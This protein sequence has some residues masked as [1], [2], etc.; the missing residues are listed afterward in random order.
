MKSKVHPRIASNPLDLA[1]SFT[2]STSNMPVRCLSYSMATNISN[3]YCQKFITSE[4]HMKTG[5]KFS[6]LSLSFD[7]LSGPH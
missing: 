7:L 3:P 5:V 4:K 6:L 1:A 2:A